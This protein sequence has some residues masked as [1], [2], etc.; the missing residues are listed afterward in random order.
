MRLAVNGGL[1]VQ[2]RLADR[3]AGGRIADL[4]HVVEVAVGVARLPL[5]RVAEKTGDVRLPF[6]VR[7]AG[8]VE[9]AAVGHRLAGE[10][11]LEVLKSLAF[12]EIH[13]LT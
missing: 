5:G 11:V 6:H 8:E 1:E 3:Q 2:L 12:V 10:G 9:I 13:L 4:A 7:L